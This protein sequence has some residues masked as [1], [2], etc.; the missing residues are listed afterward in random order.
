MNTMRGGAPNPGEATARGDAIA[1]EGS[2]DGRG[3]GP[4]P[5]DAV[6]PVGPAG[7]LDGGFE[8]L[9]FRFGRLVGLS[10]S[11]FVPIW[12]VDLVLLVVVGAPSVDRSAVGPAVFSVGGGA[13]WSWAIVAAQ[14]VALSALGIAVGAATVAWSER[15]DPSWSE[16][17]AVAVRRSWVA[18]TIVVLSMVIKLPLA[19]F[20][21][22]PWLI[23]DALV[24]TAS[25]V[26][27]A[28]RT[29]PWRALRRSIALSWRELGRALVIVTGGLVITQVLRVSFSAGPAT[30]VAIVDPSA[31]AVV[32]AER[33]GAIVGVVVEPLT[34]CIAARAYVD[35]RC[36]VEGA[37]LT[38]R[39]VERFG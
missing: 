12:L 2:P 8:L 30:I 20:A 10:A 15:R 23:G 36:R 25:V 38:R 31:T 5:L 13:A 28:E 29:G 35:L 6:R 24:F 34:A 18:A 17:V 16:L 22:V 27:G 7:V 3:I 1:P 9:R 11:L 21:L 4:T 32:F 33:L 26:A 39:R 37:D 14:A 19:C